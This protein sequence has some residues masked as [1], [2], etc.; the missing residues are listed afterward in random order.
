MPMTLN[1][2]AYPSDLTDEQWV[3]LEPLVPALSPDAAYH[4]HER[5]EIVNAILYVLR[6]G[7]PWRMLPHEFPAWGTVYDSFRQWQG[8]GVWDQV[9]RTLRMQ[10]RR[11]QDRDEEPSAAIIDSQSIKTSAVRGAD[12][13]FDMGKRIWGR[14]R[15]VLVD[16][17]GH[18]LAVKVTGA[19]I[20]DQEGGRRLLEPLKD[21]L[22]R[23]KLIWG[24]SHYGG[25]FLTWTKITLGWTIQTIKALTV[26][27]RG[28]LVSEGEEVDWDKLFPK[29]FRPLPRRWVIERTFSWIIRWRRLC[30][31]HEGLPS[32]SE[33]LITIAM[34]CRIVNRLAPPHFS[35]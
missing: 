6:S 16:T 30:R 17:Q 13:G 8:E 18:L 32:S 20:S 10:V 22:P 3:V 23:L 7:C 12:K 11:T 34:G 33:A 28:L 15:H 19:E 21:A 24:E 2:Q 31:D 26:P 9:L 35:Y 14:K 27:K 5:R 29:G 1:R 25:T 4:V